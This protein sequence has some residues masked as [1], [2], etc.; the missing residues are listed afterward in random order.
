MSTHEPLLVVD[1]LHKS[2]GDLEVL[3]GISL[4]A[5]DHDVISIIGSSGSGKSTFLRCLNILEMPTSGEII[6]KGQKMPLSKPVGSGKSQR[7]VTSE[8][9]LQTIR[10]QMGMVFQSFNLWHHLSILEN[11][12]CAQI[13]AHK[14]SKA[15][16]IETAERLLDRV[17]IADKRNQYPN[18]LSGGQQQRVAIA[19]TLAL[20]PKLILFDEPT[21]AL[22]PEMV[23]EVLKVIG[24]LAHEGRTMIV[25]TH[26]LG[27]AREISNHVVFLKDGLIG[28]QGPPEQVLGKPETEEC[29]QFLS[30]AL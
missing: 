30:M 11:V 16:A 3:K 29:Q 25:V 4:T 12:T 18:Q 21:S 9:T 8:R 5:S 7:K 2:Y 28:E 10:Q 1:D 15:E 6:F 19:R 26:E 24:D 14:K 20:D 22:D 27:F 13:L 23:G 17:G